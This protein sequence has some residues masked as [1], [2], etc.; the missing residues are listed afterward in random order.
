VCVECPKNA[1]VSESLNCP[2][3]HMV[4]P[5]PEQKYAVL[6]A[7][8]ISRPSE[9]NYFSECLATILFELIT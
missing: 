1:C 9:E 8:E 5:L 4:V 7:E 3:C 2:V 6:M